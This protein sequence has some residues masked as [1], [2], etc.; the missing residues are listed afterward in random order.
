M[1]TQSE[2]VD[3]FTHPYPHNA[4]HMLVVHDS[5]SRD[6]YPV[7]VTQDEDVREVE[8]IYCENMQQ[9]EEI[10]NLSTPLEPQLA[11]KRAYNY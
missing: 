9:I 7:Y 4:T 5:F 11:A 6:D 10:Y 3:W 1:I 2:I 8:K